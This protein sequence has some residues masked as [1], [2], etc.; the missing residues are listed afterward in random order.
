MSGNGGGDDL[1]KFLLYVGQ[2][3][4]TLRTGW[5]LRGVERVESI[6][7]HM[8]RMAVMSLLLPTISEQSKVRC[9]KLALVHDLAES[10]VGDLTEFDGIPKSEKHR[11]ESESMLHLT[12]LLPVDVGTEIFSL[13]NEY[14]DQKTNE[15]N[16]VKDLDIF[17]MLVQAYEYEKIQGE[18][19]FLEEFFQSSVSKVKTDIV[20]KWL[21]QLIQCRSST[22]QFQLP[23][24]SNLN[25]MLKYI[26]YDNQG[27]Y[28]YKLPVSDIREKVN[29][30]ISS[31]KSQND[32]SSSIDTIEH[33]TNLV[34]DVED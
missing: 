11:R 7:D 17:D 34:K 22:K 9:M 31:S 25:T 24:D 26:L 29:D 5:V 10:V 16:L 1:L 6:A 2:A 18:N 12:R 27:T 19:G 32:N 4:R 13:F 14:V 23:S 15:A 33:L 20:K 3:K 30:F 8:Y 28:L 21:E